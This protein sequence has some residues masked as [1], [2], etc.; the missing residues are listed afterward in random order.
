[1]AIYTYIY[2]TV[3]VRSAVAGP[4]SSQVLRRYQH[5]CCR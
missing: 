3:V 5:T 1:L 4:D 2:T